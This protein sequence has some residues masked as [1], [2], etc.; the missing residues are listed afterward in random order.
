MESSTL[1]SNQTMKAFYTLWVKKAHMTK[2]GILAPSSNSTPYKYVQHIL[3]KKLRE[4]SLR[5]AL[6][7]KDRNDDAVGRPAIECGQATSDQS[8]MRRGWERRGLG[9]AARHARWG[10]KEI[11]CFFI[12]AASKRQQPN[13]LARLATAAVGEYSLTSRGFEFMLPFYLSRESCTCGN[14][15]EHPG[16]N[17]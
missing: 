7:V 10:G 6:M 13:M 9:A 11:C 3:E 2:E 5:G 14:L 8:G 1:R 4:E 12:C 15:K 17:E 16:V